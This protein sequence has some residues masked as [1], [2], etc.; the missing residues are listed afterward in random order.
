M[1]IL[2]H[3]HCACVLVCCFLVQWPAGDSARVQGTIHQATP[4]LHT[5]HSTEE[6][7]PDTY[8]NLQVEVNWGIN[9]FIILFLFLFIDRKIDNYSYRMCLFFFFFNYSWPL[10]PKK[11]NI[12][13]PTSSSATV[14]PQSQHNNKSYENI[15]FPT[16]RQKID[17][18]AQVWVTSLAAGTRGQRRHSSN[19]FLFNKLQFHI[20]FAICHENSSGRSP[21]VLR[22]PPS[23]QGKVLVCSAVWN[24]CKCPSRMEQ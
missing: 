18:H 12:N 22:W 10:L 9:W 24:M 2:L 8:N 6:V 15:N 4:S 13:Q 20:N 14:S 17:S 21:A 1:M 11:Q 16:R 7:G 23:R 5:A 19:L 3:E